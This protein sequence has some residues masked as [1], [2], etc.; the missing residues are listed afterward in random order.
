MSNFLFCFYSVA[1]SFFCVWWTFI[2]PVRSLESYWLRAVEWFFGLSIV[3]VSLG[4]KFSL[5]SAGVTGKSLFHGLVV[6]IFKEHIRLKGIEAMALALIL[7]LLSELIGFICITCWCCP[8]GA[9][10]RLRLFLLIFLCFLLTL[11]WSTWWLI[12]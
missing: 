6:A 9:C 11:I 5:E 12:R 7:F 4:L 10:W 1:P 8:W 3:L 2:P